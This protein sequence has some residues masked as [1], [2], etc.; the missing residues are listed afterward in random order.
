MVYYDVVESVEPKRLAL[1]AANQTLEDANIKLAAVQQKVKELNEKLAILTI[2]LN[3]ANAAKAEAEATVA[4]GK[5]KLSL[6]AR[7][8]KALSSSNDL[9]KEG[10]G[11]LKESRE[12]LVGDTLVASAFISFIGPFTKA[13]RDSLLT[14]TWIPFITT[15]AGGD[16]I[17]MSTWVGGGGAGA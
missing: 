11:K 12:L 10:I 2:D 16:S 5:L 8:I 9:W 4:K 13:F 1:A 7:L 6:A 15:A 3:E 14:D 17:P